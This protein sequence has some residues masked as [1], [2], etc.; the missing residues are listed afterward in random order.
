MK[1]TNIF[2]Y[3]KDRLISRIRHLVYGWRF[4]RKVGANFNM[5]WLPTTKKYIPED[6]KY[7]DISYILDVFELNTDEILKD[8]N[9][10]NGDIDVDVVSYPKIKDVLKIDSR[11]GRNI[12]PYELYR[13]GHNFI[14]DDLVGYRFD[15]ESRHN[16]YQD[17]SKLFSM[18]PINKTLLKELDYFFEEIGTTQFVIVHIRRGDVI[19]VLRENISKGKV[20]DDDLKQFVMRTSPL[21]CYSETLTELNVASDVRVIISSD[22]EESANEFKRLIDADDAF[23]LG[24]YEFDALP[25]QKSFFDFLVFTKAMH[26]IGTKSSVYGKYGAIFGQNSFYNVLETYTESL[27]LDHFEDEILQKVDASETEVEHL[28]KRLLSFI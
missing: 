6:G 22:C 13:Y 2:L 9:I 20:A 3:R 21:S 18:L 19:R 4:A 12:E 17:V 8:L 23:V 14:A 10:L 5:I 11:Q 28:K 1:R 25:I 26:V 16:I 27:L 7:F 15:S 24:D